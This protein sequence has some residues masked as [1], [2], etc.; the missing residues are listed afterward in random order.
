MT[1]PY[2]FYVGDLIVTV[3]AFNRDEAKKRYNKA[4]AEYNAKIAEAERER[5]LKVI[6]AMNFDFGDYHDHTQLIKDMIEVEVK[7]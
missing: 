2:N 1:H 6:D 3:C 4:I 7:P 5:I